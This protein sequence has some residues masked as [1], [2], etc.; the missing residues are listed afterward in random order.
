MVVLVVAGR[1][2]LTSDQLTLGIV[3]IVYGSNLFLFSCRTHT[4]LTTDPAAEKRD[5]GE[6]KLVSFTVV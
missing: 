5:L 4:F 6:S 1:W 3:E 2:K